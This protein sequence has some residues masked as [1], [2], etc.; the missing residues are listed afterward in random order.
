MNRRSAPELASPGS[1]QFKAKVATYE[2]IAA[3]ASAH[4]L[5]LEGY[6]GTLVL[7]HPETAVESGVWEHMQRMAGLAP[8]PALPKS[9]DGRVA[10]NPGGH[11]A[12]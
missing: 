1:Q 10:V 4:G 12:G 5:V 7:V 2:W 9:G 11:D 6:G 8:P 3:E